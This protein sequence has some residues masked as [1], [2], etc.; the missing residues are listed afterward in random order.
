MSQDVTKEK[1]KSESEAGSDP[2][3]SSSDEEEGE[4]QEE[5]DEK[6]E[7]DPEV[8]DECKKTAEEIEEER[9]A[10]EQ[11]M[12]ERK[13]QL[14][15]RK[16][17]AEKRR[18]EMVE[19][20]DAAADAEEERQRNAEAEATAKEEVVLTS[21]ESKRRLKLEFKM[22]TMD[23]WDVTSSGTKPEEIQRASP[24]EKLERKFVS[25]MET[26]R[27]PVA[28]IPDGYGLKIQTMV[29]EL[30]DVLVEQTESL[31]ILSE[32]EVREE[33]AVKEAMKEAKR[34]EAELQQMMKDKMK[35][36]ELEIQKR[37]KDYEDAKEAVMQL[38]EYRQA[39]TSVAEMA[40]DAKVILKGLS[41]NFAVLQRLFQKPDDEK[42][43]KRDAMQLLMERAKKRR[44]AAEGSAAGTP[45]GT[46]TPMTPAKRQIQTD[47]DDEPQITKVT[48]PTP[49]PKKMPE[50]IRQRHEMKEA[51]TLE[52]Q[53]A[54]KEKLIAAR[55]EVEK[56]SKSGK[57]DDESTA[58]SVGS[59]RPAEPKGEPSKRKRRDESGE[60]S[61]D[62][63]P[64][65]W[66]TF[67]SPQGKCYWCKHGNHRAENCP[68]MWQ[69]VESLKA[70]YPK[71]P[72]PQKH[73]FCQ[74][75]WVYSREISTKSHNPKE[76]SGWGT[77]TPDICWYNPQE[78]Q[79]MRDHLRKKEVKG[80]TPVVDWGKDQ[81]KPRP[82]KREDDK[83]K[84]EDEK[85]QADEEK[86]KRKSD[87]AKGS[88]KDAPKEKKEKKRK[89]STD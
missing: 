11:L 75:C 36:K 48:R 35:E 71:E 61:L 10:Q 18:A 45:A 74:H 26:L 84:E 3:S 44:E 63:L 20:A 82:L 33:R 68:K 4:K 39:V 29:E 60:R 14:E 50:D 64:A 55:A 78:S 88:S 32:D 53:K 38:D 49:I 83:K 15:E 30:E 66:K 43:R 76:Y 6:E 42:E 7:K 12:K 79:T 70:E 80:V 59:Q 54:L 1:E 37:Q 24:T 89:S 58:E 40:K 65:K 31:S 41:E 62:N 16:E 25:F 5:E 87:K 77:H 28:S 9:K 57:K 52:K 13:E 34:C 22:D 46:R 56:M 8:Q 19:K 47:E 86:K 2:E 27:K 23:I 69:M 85:K 21:E 81:M 51:D 17:A 72:K 73:I 67:K